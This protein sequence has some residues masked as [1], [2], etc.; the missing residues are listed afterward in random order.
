MIERR[1]TGKPV[2]IRTT[3]NSMVISGYA[4]VFNSFSEDLGGFVERI[5][6]GAFSNILHDDVRALWN[7]DPNHVLGRTVSGTLK[8]RQDEV[9]LFYEIQPPNTQAARDLRELILRGD[10]DQSSFGF[11]IA[12]DGDTW[13]RDEDG[14]VIRT[15]TTVNKL[16]DVSP[17]TYP[18]YTETKAQARQ[19][20]EIAERKKLITGTNN[21]GQMQPLD[22]PEQMYLAEM[23]KNIIKRKFQIMED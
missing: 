22:G 6:P 20:F 12:E 5:A 11:T 4:A 18:A 21:A 10:V 17:A 1:Y 14:T 8:L 16:Y 3:D 7:H 2:E 9:G 19:L 15:I 13:D 23:R